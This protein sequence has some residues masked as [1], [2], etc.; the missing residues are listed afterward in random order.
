[1]MDWGSNQGLPGLLSFASVWGAYVMVTALPPAIT[2]W[3]FK[4]KQ[5]T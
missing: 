1:M 4:F 2:A 3:G 5:R